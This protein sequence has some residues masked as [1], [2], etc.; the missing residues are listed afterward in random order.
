[1]RCLVVAAT[2]LFTAAVLIL[3]FLSSSVMPKVITLSVVRSLPSIGLVAFVLSVTGVF[4][5][6]FFEKLKLI[7]T[8]DG[9]NFG[10]IMSISVFFVF[11]VGCADAGGGGGTFIVADADVFVVLSWIDGGD[12]IVNVAV[13][14]SAFDA[15]DGGAVIVYDAT[16]VSVD[17]LNGMVTV[18]DA[19][20]ALVDDVAVALLSGD[21]LIAGTRSLAVLA[22]VVV[23]V[24]VAIDVVLVAEFSF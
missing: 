12:G 5:T 4:S 14:T 13:F 9:D 20:D 6:L 1:M 24:V 23:V 19:L 2:V 15:A 16:T 17:E 7:C 18:L 3:S 22:V 10:D 11:V 21:D 8:F